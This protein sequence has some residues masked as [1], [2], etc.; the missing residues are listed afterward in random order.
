MYPAGVT[1]LDP[2]DPGFH[3]YHSRR[4][5][6]HKDAAYHNGAVWPWL[7]G[8]AMQRMLELVWC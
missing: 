5:V 3:P 7:N 2:R 8:I 1:T 4:G 6:Y